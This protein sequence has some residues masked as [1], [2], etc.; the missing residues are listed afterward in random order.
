LRCIIFD[1]IFYGLTWALS[2]PYGLLSIQPHWN[3]RAEQSRRSQ[4]LNL[5]IFIP[6]HKIYNRGDSIG[7]KCVGEKWES[8]VPVLWKRRGIGLRAAGIHL[9][10]PI[11][12]LCV[13]FFFRA[14]STRKSSLI[15]S[16]LVYPFS[17][18]VQWFS[19]TIIV[20]EPR[21]PSS[22]RCTGLLIRGEQNLHPHLLPLAKKWGK[23]AMMSLFVVSWKCKIIGL[24]IKR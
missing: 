13:F 23:S 1:N 22:D 5:L 6:G 17:S 15:S 7:Q 4:K 16:S 21:S 18:V 14:I 9:I 3:R 8:N 12:F 24:R 11:P 2:D 20:V 10:Q 19:T